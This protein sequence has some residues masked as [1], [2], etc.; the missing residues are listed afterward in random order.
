MPDVAHIALNYSRSEENYTYTGPKLWIFPQHAFNKT[1]T[2]EREN[3]I[4]LGQSS[5]KKTPIEISLANPELL[6]LDSF[7]H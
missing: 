1:S 7:K 2:A 3:N 5:Y 6:A 4:T